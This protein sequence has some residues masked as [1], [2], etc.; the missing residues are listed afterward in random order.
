MIS[1]SLIIFIVLYFITG[2]VIGD[3]LLTARA[4]FYEDRWRWGKYFSEF[5]VEPRQPKYFLI[6]LLC[7][8]FWPFNSLNPRISPAIV[9]MDPR[10]YLLL[11]LIGWPF[12][13]VSSI[14]LCLIAL[15]FMAIIGLGNARL[16]LLDLRR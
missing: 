3:V 16:N 13:I 15:L 2:F 10:N 14:V 1:L 6:R 8:L 4:R 12:K 7:F 11:I 9:D 5:L